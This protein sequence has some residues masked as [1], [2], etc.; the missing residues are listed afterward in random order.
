MKRW[1]I[2]KR[3]LKNKVS[4][5]IYTKPMGTHSRVNTLTVLSQGSNTYDTPDVR[6]TSIFLYK[7]IL[8]E[9]FKK[10]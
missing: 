7:S 10:V 3:G 1:K 4:S 5:S 8:G 6:L 9:F 2:K